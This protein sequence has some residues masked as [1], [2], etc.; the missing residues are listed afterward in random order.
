LSRWKI[1][2][3]P[4]IA[5]R[6]LCSLDRIIAPTKM[7]PR[8]MYTARRSAFAW[9]VYGKSPTPLLKAILR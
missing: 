1:Q 2:F 8:P 6:F 5:I 4:S 3:N 9:C 7:K